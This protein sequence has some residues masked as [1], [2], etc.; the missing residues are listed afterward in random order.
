[1]TRCGMCIADVNETG[2]DFRAALDAQ[3]AT[4]RERTP[5]R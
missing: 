2:L 3:G 4:R 5:G 1:M